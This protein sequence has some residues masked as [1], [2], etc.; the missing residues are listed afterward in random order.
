MSELEKK[1]NLPNGGFPPIYLIDPKLKKEE[2][3]NKNREFSE[4]SSS[5]NIKDILNSRKTMSDTKK[6]LFDI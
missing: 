1:N 6:K 2:E 4:I 3:K 5:F